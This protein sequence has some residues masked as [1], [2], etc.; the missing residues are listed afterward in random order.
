M[1]SDVIS[2]SIC[3]V[4]GSL[5]C[6]SSIAPLRG[7]TASFPKDEPVFKT[8]VPDGYAATETETSLYLRPT[9]AG[10]P[11][12]FF[13]FIALPAGDVSDEA[14]A[15]KYVEAYRASELK[16]LNVEEGRTLWPIAEESLPNGLKGW[17]ADSD[18]FMKQKK[19]DLPQ[20]VA[21]TAIVFPPDG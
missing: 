21:F 1:I 13:A 17:S 4:I 7:E 8:E 18:Y 19:G 10:G 5:L 14:S 9:A 3:L 15:K 16:K 12:H 11:G 20:A 6:L 2:R